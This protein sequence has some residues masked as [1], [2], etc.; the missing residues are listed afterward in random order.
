MSQ[1]ATSEGFFAQSVPR[2]DE[3]GDTP[4]LIF[5]RDPAVWSVDTFAREQ[6]Q[7][8]L[9][10]LFFP[11][12]GNGVN[13]VLFSPIDRETHIDSIA[14]LLGDALASEKVGSVAVMGQISHQISLPQAVVSE[15][16]MSETTPLRQ[17]GLRLKENLW[18]VP[19]TIEDRM[20]MTPKLLARI[21]N[22]RR[23][24]DYSI[25]VGPPADSH[26]ALAM[27]AIADGIVLALS[28]GHTRRATARNVMRFLESTNARILGTVLT[29]R[30]FP[31][32]A[33]IYRRL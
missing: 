14:R 10:T 25:V 1:F 16:R 5:R 7:G 13:H 22:L 23:E 24:F 8:L 2:A 12:H 15:G 33:K 21:C 6:L 26:E 31:I 17:T 18:V 27:A 11:P 9:Q 20:S 30:V 28:A 4:K 3:S 32:P 19:E 29:D